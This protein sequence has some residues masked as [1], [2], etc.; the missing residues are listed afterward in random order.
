M[1]I[2]RN[3]ASIYPARGEGHHARRRTARITCQQT[4]NKR[5]S[6]GLDMYR[7]WEWRTR[8]RYLLTRAQERGAKC[9]VRLRVKDRDPYMHAASRRFAYPFDVVR[10]GVVPDR[11]TQRWT[12]LWENSAL[13]VKVVPVRPQLTIQINSAYVIY[14]C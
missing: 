12:Y 5:I 10:F 11:W 1:D 3:E 8:I 4:Q 7:I 13:E 2:I 14:S 9:N 6:Q